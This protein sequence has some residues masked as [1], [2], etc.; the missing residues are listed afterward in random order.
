MGG[1]GDNPMHTMASAAD[2][3]LFI[4]NSRLAIGPVFAFAVADIAMNVTFCFSWCSWMIL[5][6]MVY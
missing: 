6:F 5:Y 2:E 3:V 1:R 4:N